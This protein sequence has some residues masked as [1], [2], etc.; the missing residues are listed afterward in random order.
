MKAEE[1]IENN[2]LQNI[3]V[4]SEQKVV[5]EEITITAVSMAR[6]EERERAYR[7]LESVF[8]RWVS[9]CDFAEC[10]LEEIKAELGII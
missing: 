7:V 1:L 2:A 10:M 4:E 3:K 6:I 9:G 5:F 8:E